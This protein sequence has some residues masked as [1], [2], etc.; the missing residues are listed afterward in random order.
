MTSLTAKVCPESAA[1]QAGNSFLN[2]SFFYGTVLSCFK[3]YPF[4]DHTT[5]SADVG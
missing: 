1:R 3:Q 2:L 4:A 5:V